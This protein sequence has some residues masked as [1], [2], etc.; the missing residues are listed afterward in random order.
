MNIKICFDFHD[1]FVDA[2]KAWIKAFT[3]FCNNEEIVNDY[4]NKMSKKEICKKYGLD[5]EAVE[6]KY[7]EY[8]TPLN[9]NIELAKE[10]KKYYPI[11]LISLSRDTRLKKDLAKFSLY[12]TFNSIYS[13][14]DVINRNEFLQKYSND[15]EMVVYFNHEEPSVKLINKVIY[16]PIDTEVKI[17]KGTIYIK[18]EGIEIKID[19]D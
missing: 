11:D 4:N 15:S 13:K 19:I 7:R 12:E 1:I 6:E 8:L 3:F 5:Y 2:K 10:I 14:L 9:K 16:V 18:S 17:S